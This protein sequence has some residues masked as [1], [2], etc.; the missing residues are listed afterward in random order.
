MV[1]L[2]YSESQG[3]KLGANSHLIYQVGLYSL[4][5]LF[6]KLFKR[7]RNAKY[8]LIP[9]HGFALEVFNFMRRPAVKY[10][11]EYQK[12]AIPEVII[13][14]PVFSESF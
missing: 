10:Q 12:R 9:V 13:F 3:Q 8:D 7:D 1:N 11:F 14:S 5:S 2:G 4:S 6:A